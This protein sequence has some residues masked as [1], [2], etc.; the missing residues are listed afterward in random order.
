MK[1]TNQRQP[2][3]KELQSRESIYAE[4]RNP[5]LSPLPIKF[6]IIFLS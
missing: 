4:Y 2:E 5:S 1:Q 3:A 6:N